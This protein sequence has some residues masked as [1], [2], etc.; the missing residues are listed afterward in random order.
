MFSKIENITYDNEGILLMIKK[1]NHYEKL[2]NFNERRCC[3]H[4]EKEAMVII[5]LM[6][7]PRINHPW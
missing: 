2:T 3:K 4:L 5:R 6:G 7:S 1:L